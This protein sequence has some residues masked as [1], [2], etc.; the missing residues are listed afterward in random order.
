MIFAK[1]FK[2]IIST[3]SFHFRIIIYNAPNFPKQKIEDTI[4]LNII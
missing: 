3:Y 4:N 2:N 1:Y